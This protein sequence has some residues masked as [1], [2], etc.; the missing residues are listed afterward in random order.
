MNLLPV[1]IALSSL[2]ALSHSTTSKDRC[3]RTC[4]T[5][6]TMAGRRLRGCAPGGYHHERRR[7]R[8]APRAG[9]GRSASAGVA[10]K[11][12]GRWS[13]HKIAL[14]EPLCQALIP[15]WVF[16]ATPRVF[17]LASS[18]SSARTPAVVGS[19]GGFAT[20]V[21]TLGGLQ[22]RPDRRLAAFI[23]TRQLGHR[24]PWRLRLAL[25]A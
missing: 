2:A 4:S 12:T 11:G 8:Q 9:C 23:L 25:L 17:S 10:A 6:S 19:G 18:H 14:W 24:A 20:E 21:R 5:A 1:V 13:A 7:D 16:G 3:S 22:R 15:S